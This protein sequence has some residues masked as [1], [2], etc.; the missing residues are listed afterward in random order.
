MRSKDAFKPR[1]HQRRTLILGPD[2]NS[3]QDRTELNDLIHAS[4]QNPALQEQMM[5]ASLEKPTLAEQN[6]RHNQ[7]IS[8]G[9]MLPRAI[10]SHR[11][12]DDEEEFDDDIDL[13]DRINRFLFFRHD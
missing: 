10:T 3:T 6:A 8:T 7:N 12:R 11:E 4:L 9:G 2:L 13:P 5:N 1:L